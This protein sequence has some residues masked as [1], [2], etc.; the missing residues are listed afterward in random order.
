MAP[1]RSSAQRC[2]LT[3]F[4]SMSSRASAA[5][6]LAAADLAAFDCFGSC[7]AR[8]PV[9]R[10]WRAGVECESACSTTWGVRADLHTR[11][12][13]SNMCGMVAHLVFCCVFLFLN[14]EVGRVKRTSKRRVDNA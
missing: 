12:A 11:K 1:L 10:E 5:A 4:V 8:R 3:F 7:E 14:E 2:V 9:A 6:K 13:H